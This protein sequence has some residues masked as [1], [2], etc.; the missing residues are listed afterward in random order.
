VH[1]EWKK[2]RANAEKKADRNKTP[3]ERDRVPFGWFPG[4]REHQGQRR[5]MEATA[6]TND[7]RCRDQDEEEQY[8]QMESLNPLRMT[9]QKEEESRASHLSF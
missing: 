6:T 3:S 5:Q 2:E 1:R 8:V 7:E 4:P 9:F